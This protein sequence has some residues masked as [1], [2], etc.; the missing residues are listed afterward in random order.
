L[1]RTFLELQKHRQKM[2]KKKTR[3]HRFKKGVQPFSQS[4]AEYGEKVESKWT[5]RLS[6]CQFAKVCR[7]DS[8]GLVT[9]PDIHGA[10]GTAKMLRPKPEEADPSPIDVY[11]TPDND[12]ANIV[13][14]TNIVVNRQK[15]MDMMNDVYLIHSKKSTECTPKFKIDHI[16]LK[17]TTEKWILRCELCKFQSDT[18][19]LYETVNSPKKGAKAATVNVGL[20]VG[21]QDTAMGQSQLRLLFAA[22]NMSAGSK[23]TRQRKGNQVG[24]KTVELNKADMANRLQELSKIHEL[25]GV[26]DDKR[27]I[28]VQFDGQYHSNVFGSRRKH[29]QAPSLAIGT[30]IEDVTDQHQI[31]AMAVANKLCW[32]GTWLR[33]RG[34]NA[35]CPGGHDGECTATM[36]PYIPFSERDLAYDCG[37]DI[38][39][40]DIIVDK[41][42]TD[43]DA[44]GHEGI[45]QAMKDFVSPMLTV[46]RLTDPVHKGQGQIHAGLKAEFNRE[47]FPI[48]TGVPQ[49]DMQKAFMLDVKNRCSLIVSALFKKYKNTKYMS[50]KL[51]SIVDSVV[52]CYGGDC[53]K[54]KSTINGCEAGFKYT[55][56]KK[57][58]TMVGMQWTCGS[59]FLDSN[60][61]LYLRTILEMKLSVSALQE[62]RLQTNTNACESFNSTLGALCPKRVTYFRNAQGR[63]HAAAHRRNNEVGSSIVLKLEASGAPI[64]KGSRA[65]NDLKQLQH[66]VKYGVSYRK[67]ANVQVRERKSKSRHLAG[68]MNAKQNKQKTG[69]YRKRQ[70]DTSPTV[71]TRRRRAVKCEEQSTCD[72]TYST[73]S[74]SGMPRRQSKRIAPG[75]TSKY[76]RLVVHVS[77]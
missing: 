25:R 56:W 22:A 74:G 28:N 24:D 18:Y 66:Q 63:S 15:V 72:H 64:A 30:V 75:L 67:R 52:D 23:S 54:C 33:N 50:D 8:S 41:I 21:L 36:D 68:I 61:R 57:S 20:Q 46:E 70:L 69:D 37:K 16:V 26:T 65:A 42:T 60:D 45:Q 40:Q 51:A 32:R 53:S 1:I 44:K 10:S 39:L 17:G 62:M 73:A 34:I 11:Q 76:P 48:H 58:T 13:A 14:N 29:G 43:G 5:K 71:L 9:I 2:P 27:K 59:L 12:T 35:T 55:W 19:P 4:N 47:M 77:Y 49:A 38:A 3:D 7:T 31:V 6:N